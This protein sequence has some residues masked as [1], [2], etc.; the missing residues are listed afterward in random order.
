MI[1]DT[2]RLGAVSAVTAATNT[3]SKNRQ[4]SDRVG[5]D[6]TQ[7]KRSSVEYVEKLDA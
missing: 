1:F 2:G 5:N 6:L 7:D 4:S 3:A